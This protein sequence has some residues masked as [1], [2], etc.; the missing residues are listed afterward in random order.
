MRD[1]CSSFLVLSTFVLWPGLLQAQQGVIVARANDAATARPLPTVQ[2]SVTGGG[3]RTGGLTG[4]AGRV[5]VQVPPGTYTVTFELIG[6][7]T[8]VVEGVQVAAGESVDVTVS[9][10]ESAITLGGIVVSASKRLEK[11]TSAP[12]TMYTV[13]ERTV[14]ERP[15]ATPADYLV[16]APGVDIMRQGIQST[17]VVVRGFNNVFSG[18]LH[19]L[20]DNRI[21]GVPSLRV[22]LLHFIP[23]NDDDVARMEVVLGPGSALYGPNTANG[24]LHL[25]TKS[26]LAEQETTVSVAG[27]NRDVFK[28]MF[29]T[30]H[31]L[32]EDEN[33]G[34]KLSGQFMRGLDWKYVDPF[35]QA[36][37]DQA[38]ENP[39]AFRANLVRAGF[40]QQQAQTAFERVGLR[41]YD[42]LRY[43][44]EIRADWRLNDAA[45]WIFQTGLTSADGIE[46]TGIGAAQASDWVYS[47]YQTR[48]N[49]D[50][51]F[52]QVYLNRSSNDDSF[53]VRRGVALVDN[54]NMLVGQV[55]HGFGLGS[56]MDDGARRQD[57]T[58]GLDVFLTTPQTEGR[59]NGQYEDDDKIDEVGGYIQSETALTERLDLIAAA[60][61]DK[62]SILDDA[63][64]SPRAALVWEAVPDQSF[65]LTYNRAFSTP[66]TL[67]YFLDVNGGLAGFSG[68]ERLGF[69]T[70]A[71]G[72]GQDGLS[73]RRADGSFYGVRSPLG[74]PSATLPAEPAALFPFLVGL[75]Q[76]LAAAGQIPANVPALLQQLGPAGLG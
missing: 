37:R 15:A 19:A 42:F 30:S 55:Q 38:D 4:D 53:L 8:R 58:Y 66:T 22:N 26:P 1:R 56:E 28:G 24:V 69:F 39:E 47:Y 36:A 73:F 12:A 40:T 41:D 43:G 3:T 67:N 45:T 5:A 9:L 62:S 18:A 6:R 51:L 60:R 75:A 71:Q 54:S 17:N 14:E 48:F 16:G 31:L 49:W 65:R 2:V 23:S 33:F 13:S 29:R 21:A 68:N 52:A 27:G 25:I 72:P 46:L 32:G 11:R 61:V 7:E 20:T 64:F 63:I 70:R 10:E 44:G 34:I 74:D 35:E 76:Q 50:R 59:I 57:F